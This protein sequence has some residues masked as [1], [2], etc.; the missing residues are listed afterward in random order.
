MRN[1]EIDK[2]AIRPCL[3][4]GLFYPDDIKE[5]IPLLDRKLGEHPEGGSPLILT[6]HGSYSVCGETIAAGFASSRNCSPKTVVLL[7]PV[8]REKTRPCLY[9]PETDYFET[10]LGPLEVNTEIKKALLEQEGPFREDNTPHMEE[11]GLEVQLPFIRHLYPEARILPILTGHLNRKEIRKAAGI[12]N[13]ALKKEL[14]GVLTVITLNMTDFLPLENARTQAET[15][16]GMIR[17]PLEDS[18][19]EEEKKGS[20]STCGSVVLTLA[21]EAFPTAG[22]G[23]LLYGQHSEVNDHG[24]VKGVIYASFSWPDFKGEQ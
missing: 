3:V 22:K 1:K 4:S 9:L 8:H 17:F 19:L 7:G 12:L 18:L 23:H 21:S 24:T 6:P 10:P 20:I 2:E 13:A 11:H 14:R 5:L 16:T 15:L